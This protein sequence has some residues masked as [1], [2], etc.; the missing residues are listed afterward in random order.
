MQILKHLE[1]LVTWNRLVIWIFVS[2]SFPAPIQ[3]STP[4]PRYLIGQHSKGKV[5]I[6][7]YQIKEVV[8]E[9]FMLPVIGVSCNYLHIFK[10]LR[11]TKYCL[12]K[13][14]SLKSSVIYCT[15]KVCILNTMKGI[16]SSLHRALL[17]PWYFCAKHCWCNCTL[18]SNSL[19][20]QTVHLPRE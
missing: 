6:V 9:R 2:F 1:K 3:V 11:P 10:P 20:H 14:F 7:F 16:Y 5:C 17:Y 18:Y 4:C 12:Q 15:I 8:K 19:K 13:I